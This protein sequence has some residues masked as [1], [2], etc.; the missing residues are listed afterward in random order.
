MLENMSTK[1]VSR[2]Y[3]FDNQDMTFDVVAEFHVFNFQA[4]V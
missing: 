1:D 4:T 3:C 2:T